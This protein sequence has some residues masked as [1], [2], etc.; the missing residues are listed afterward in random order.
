MDQSIQSE[1]K[2][3]TIYL[4]STSEEQ[5]ELESLVKFTKVFKPRDLRIKD[6]FA[7]VEMPSQE[8]VKQIMA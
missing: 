1:I 2:E 3:N 7:V 5:I 8:A 6:G 4:E